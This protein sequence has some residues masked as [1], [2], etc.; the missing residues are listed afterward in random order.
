MNILSHRGYW[1][2]NE[3][4][5]TQLAFDR[6]FSLGYGT[7][8]DIR[9]FNGELVIS[10]DITQ[11]SEMSLRAF[12]ALTSSCQANIPLTLALNIK[13]DGLAPLLRRALDAYPELD[14]F[15]FDMSVPDTRSYFDA[16]IPVFARMSEVEQTPAW[17]ARSTGVWL[18]AFESEWYN[19][20]II[21]TLL[22][23]NKRVCIVSP[24]LHK[25]PYL[26]LWENLRSLAHEPA[27]MLCTDYPE[28][29]TAFFLKK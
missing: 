20:S 13:A 5:N 17:L 27:L 7:E 26:P 21:K 8:T 28:E 4:K 10:H 16:K 23:Q 24:E 6:S 3:E 29:A 2:S 1:K 25:R 22:G 15:V 9:D 19:A 18:D 14:C 12:L 11:G